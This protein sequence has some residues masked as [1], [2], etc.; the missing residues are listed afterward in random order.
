[1][2]Q[3]MP[4]KKSMIAVLV[5]SFILVGSLAR[6][7]SVE[8]VIAQVDKEFVDGYVDADT[9]QDLILTLN[10]IMTSVGGADYASNVEAFG[11][12]VSVN[13]GNTIHNDAADR[14]LQLADGL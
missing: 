1:M 7:T 4:W 2:K 11:L 9:Y 13:A 8:E 3:D 6:A 5:L 14:I 12:I 10:N